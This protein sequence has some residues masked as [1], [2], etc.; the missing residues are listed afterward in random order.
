MNFVHAKISNR[1][2]HSFQDSGHKTKLLREFA[3][4]SE[5]NVLKT[6]KAMLTSPNPL[7]NQYFSLQLTIW[8]YFKI[9]I[10]TIMFG[11]IL[12]FYKKPVKHVF[13]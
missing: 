7:N 12:I 13:L 4:K 11:L 8:L 9:K 2:T 10:I 1:D 5:N 3:L 6:P